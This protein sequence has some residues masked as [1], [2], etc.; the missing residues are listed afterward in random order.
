MAFNFSMQSVHIDLSVY[1]AWS[2]L[3]NGKAKCTQF[4]HFVYMYLNHSLLTDDRHN[5]TDVH[6]VRECGVHHYWLLFMFSNRDRKYRHFSY[7]GSQS[8]NHVI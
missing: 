5:I 2:K 4:L 8:D 6:Y 1:T 7:R 3:D